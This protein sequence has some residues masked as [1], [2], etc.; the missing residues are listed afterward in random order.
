[1]VVFLFISFFSFFSIHFLFG[2]DFHL[3]IRIDIE[4]KKINFLFFCS[5]AGVSFINDVGFDAKSGFTISR[6]F[7]A[8]FKSVSTH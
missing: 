4:K 8:S 3:V 2:L 1:M 6:Y 5:G 7:R